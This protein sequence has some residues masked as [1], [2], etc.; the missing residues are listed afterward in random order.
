LR[1][2]IVIPRWAGSSAQASRR[3][4][5]ETHHRDKRLNHSITSDQSAT[6]YSWKEPADSGNIP[7]LPC[8]SLH[9][10]ALVFWRLTVVM[11][12][13]R[14]VCSGIRTPHGPT[15]TSFD[16]ALHQALSDNHDRLL[17]AS[18]HSSSSNS[19]DCNPIV[20]LGLQHVSG[21]TPRLFTASRPKTWKLRAYHL[22]VTL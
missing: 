14:R 4:A 8:L 5:Y 15:K 17:N 12:R 20:T 18:R 19:P 22:D 7:L 3:C 1:R 13:S 10:T 6:A 16:Q 21:S 9:A 2:L 11:Q